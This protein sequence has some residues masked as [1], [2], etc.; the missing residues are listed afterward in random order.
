MA[1]DF[2][3]VVSHNTS[4]LLDWKLS[5]MCTYEELKEKVGKRVKPVK[6]SARQALGQWIRNDDYGF[7]IDVPPPR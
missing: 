6:H 2:I 3:D 4:Y 7:T 1:Q 5:P